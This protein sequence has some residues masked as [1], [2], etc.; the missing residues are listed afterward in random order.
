M[1]TITD[2]KSIGTTLLSRVTC[3]HCWHK[4]PPDETNWVSVHPDLRG[5]E[6]LDQPGSK[7]SPRR[8][9]PT[10]FS[11]E[12]LALDVRGQ[13]CRETACPHCHLSV[14]RASLELP[15]SIVSIIGSP[16]SGKSYFLAS[17]IWQA[18]KT[19]SGKFDL[20]FADADLNLN[21]MVNGY[22]SLLFMQDEEDELIQIAKT[23]EA[24]DLYDRVYFE[25]YR[26]VNYAKPFLFTVKPESFHHYAAKLAKSSRLLVLYDNAGEHFSPEKNHPDQPGTGHLEHAQVLFFLFDPTQH[27]QFR[28]ECRKFS[29][30]P[31]LTDPSKVNSQ[32]ILLNEAG[33]RVRQWTG[34][35]HSQKDKRPLVV[36]VTKYDVWAPMLSSL[37]PKEL[38]LDQVVFRSRQGLCGL[39]IE[40]LAKVSKIV[41]RFLRENT[42]E[43]VTAAHSLSEEVVFIPVS[44]L[45][46]SPVKNPH[47]AK[48]EGFYV[49]PGS[50]KPQWAEVPLLYALHRTSKRL[51]PGLKAKT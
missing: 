14:T 12:G 16:G 8:F 10:R 1:S 18:R 42:P 26:T 47:P 2:E 20:S 30:D 13:V 6:R 39:R 38:S 45:G 24:G 7:E 48:Q 31:Q 22:E 28:R 3:P 40:E 21:A 5:D 11:V 49:R 32:H 41:E 37:L 29:T 33:S 44:S 35:S 9:L 46:T 23:Q 4:F 43:I 36:I 19:L 15:P 51:V 25:N 34:L 50:I 27:P 17:M